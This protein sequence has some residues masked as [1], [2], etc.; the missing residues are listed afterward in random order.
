MRTGYAEVRRLHEQAFAREPGF[1]TPEHLFYYAEVLWALGAFGEA[2]PVY[3]EVA[4]DRAGTFA[5]VAAHD[6]VLAYEQQTKAKPSDAR[7]R[8]AIAAADLFLQLEP[9]SGEA[10]HVAWYAA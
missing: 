1:R 10:P 6:M 8:E 5:H 2:A 9:G 4:L 3:R 7:R